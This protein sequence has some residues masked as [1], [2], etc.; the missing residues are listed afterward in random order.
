MVTR[1]VDQ[2][3]AAARASELA[4]HVGHRQLRLRHVPLY[5]IAGAEAARRAAGLGFDQTGCSLRLTKQREEAAAAVGGSVR[6][7]SLHLKTRRVG[8]SLKVAD[9][10]EIDVLIA[11]LAERFKRFVRSEAVEC[12]GVRMRRALSLRA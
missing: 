7:P 1:A 4:L 9:A 6:S 10:E 3:R 2:S 5:G 11:E 8:K 12:T